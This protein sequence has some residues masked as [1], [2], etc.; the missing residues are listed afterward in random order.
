MSKINI[1][2]EKISNKRVG[3]FYTSDS[4][5]FM[6]KFNFQN[7]PELKKKVLEFLDNN[8]DTITLSQ[9][10]NKKGR[11]SVTRAFCK[12]KRRSQKTSERKLSKESKEELRE[13]VSKI[14]CKKETSS[15]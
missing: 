11:G 8:F 5:I 2:K 6:F 10:S 4:K 15:D 7:N 12:R 13:I 3:E 9:N 14:D 1:L